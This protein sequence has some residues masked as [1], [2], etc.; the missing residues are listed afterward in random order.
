[1][2]RGYIIMIMALFFGFLETIYFGSHWLP[3]CNAE[4]AADGFTTAL[5]CLGLAVL[6]FEERK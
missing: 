4:L 1:M 2:K 5:A 3:S 6:A